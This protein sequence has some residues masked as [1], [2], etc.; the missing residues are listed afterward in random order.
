MEKLIK[1]MFRKVLNA[2]KTI[3]KDWRYSFAVI[4]IALIFFISNVIISNYDTI[5]SS[6]KTLGVLGT[7]QFIFFLSIGFHQTVFLSSYFSII[8][9]AL[10]TG[11][12][13]TLVFYKT[14]SLRNYGDSNTKGGLFASAGIFLGVIAPGCA[15]CGVGLLAIFGVSAATLS[16]LPFKGLEISLAAIGILTYSVFSISKGLNECSSCQVN[17]NLTKKMNNR[18][19]RGSNIHDR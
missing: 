3:Y 1:N 10:L 13:L 11:M 16:V 2:W 12:L 5:I 4:F 15:A 17:L 7:L 18:N 19:E 14:R 6:S 9:I 8:A